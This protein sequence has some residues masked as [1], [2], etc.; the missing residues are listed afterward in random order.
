MLKSGDSWIGR[1]YAYKPIVVRSKDNLL[2]KLVDVE[3]TAA[4]INYM[5]AEII[6]FK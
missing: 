2:G 3:V 5:E 6:R 1:N 4:H